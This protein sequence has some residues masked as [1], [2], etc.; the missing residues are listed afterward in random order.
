MRA[1]LSVVLVAALFVTG[2]AAARIGPN[3]E[4]RLP[5]LA[6]DELL[7]VNVSLSEQATPA[8]LQ[9]LNATL[10]PE[11]ARAAVI[12]RLK[13]IAADTQ[14]DL[15][16]YLEGRR[17]LGDVGY[18]GAFW[19]TNLVVCEARPSVIRELLERGDVAR[20][21]TGSDRPD[22]WVGVGES[23]RDGGL[24]WG[25]EKIGAPYVWDDYGYDGDGIV[26]AVSDTGVNYE[27]YDLRDHL[28]HNTDEIP[29]NG[30]DDDHNGY[31]D[32]YLGY[33][34][35]GAGGGGPDP[36]DTDGHGT[37]CAGSVSS[38]GAAGMSC[39]VAP[40]TRIMSLK[41]WMW[42][43][44]QGEA[45]VWEAWQYALDNGAD[46]V[47]VSLGWSYGW[48][49]DRATWRDV[50]EN[51]LAGGLAL[52][53]A[54]GNDGPDPQT[55]T[56]PGDVPGLITVGAT[57]VSDEIA[58][59]S[60]RGPVSWADVA[61][62]H[63]YPCLTKPDVC[64][65]GVD[66]VSCSWEDDQGYIWGWNGTSMATPHTAGTVSLLLDAAPALSPVQLKAALEHYARELGDPGKDNTYGAGRVN[67]FASVSSVVADPELHLLFDGYEVA[68]EDSDGVLEPGETATVYCRLYNMS[69]VTATGVTADLST[70]SD[71]VTVTDGHDSLGSLAP[72]EEASAEFTLEVDSDC[73]EPAGLPLDLDVH[74]T[75][76]YDLAEAFELFVP[77]YGLREDCESGIEPLW[78]YSSNGENTWRRTDEDS[79]YGRY[80]FTPNDVGGGY[81]PNLDC[82]LVSLPFRVDAE[83]YILTVWSKF[84]LEGGRDALYVEIRYSEEDDWTVL[85]TLSGTLGNWI[86]RTNDLTEHRGEIAQLRLRFKSDSDD[87]YDGAF[88][89][90]IYVV[91]YEVGVGDAALSARSTDDGALLGWDITGDVAG[92]YIYRQG[93]ARS[94]SGLGSRLNEQP[95]TGNRGYYLD[96]GRGES[97]VFEVTDADGNRELLG[98]VEVEG[99]TPTVN[100]TSLST[101][102][103]NPVSDTATIRFELG[104]ED[105]SEVTLAVYDL[106]GRRVAVLFDGD[107]AA[108][109]HTVAWDTT[110]VSVGVYLIRL[111]TAGGSLTRRAVVVR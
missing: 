45:S 22:E 86:K 3:L 68:D 8:E 92:I 18:V 104:G 81:E 54:G 16:A 17:N 47:S 10:P 1:R 105:G 78:R 101:P 34:F 64:A 73:P 97:Y 40:K 87:T 107:L 49:P 25:V 21:E 108:G 19:V 63:D 53:V 71:D 72:F 20:V 23:D 43:T 15:L 13:Y 91:D 27:H 66:I 39:G 41:V 98:P 106:A 60:G 51:C 80:S 11:P 96:R 12:E 103:P 9:Q 4:A 65:P 26:V 56:C 88:A 85:H 62:Y 61:P 100:R 82:S 79:V 74:A 70:D 110:G 14:G 33:Y 111:V 57:N 46:A 95:L 7:W 67:A 48:D 77:G 99:G 52:V 29:D 6:E 50:A 75:N 37:H 76:P 90:Q 30:V 5:G 24:A 109:R 83:H 38:D 28:W 59:F 32:D 55:I 31:V 58:G 94:S 89:D 93:D 42:A 69:L 84:H 44:P 102:F 35:D 36:M 2:A